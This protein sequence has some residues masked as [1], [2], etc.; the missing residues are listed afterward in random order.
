M[1]TKQEF[2]IELEKR[3]S[4]LKTF[5]N[6]PWKGLAALTE[7]FGINRNDDSCVP[8]NLQNKEIITVIVLEIW[9]YMVL[10]RKVSVSYWIIRSSFTFQKAKDPNVYEYGFDPYEEEYGYDPFNYETRDGKVYDTRSKEDKTEMAYSLYVDA[11]TFL[12]SQEDQENFYSFVLSFE[13]F[14]VNGS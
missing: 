14:H 5:K 13:A 6:H 4:L 1:L 7:K 11:Y 3:I 2:D 8:L 10:E 9:W 12:K